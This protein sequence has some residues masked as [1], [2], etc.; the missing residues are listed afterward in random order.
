M[1][2]HTAAQFRLVVGF[3]GS[4]G[5][6]RA[7]SWAADEARQRSAKLEVVRAWTPG[8]FGTNEEMGTLT[9][10]RLEEDLA[11]VLGAPP[12]G[13]VAAVAIQGHAAKVLLEQAQDADMLVVGSRGHGG[14]TGLV[15]GSVGVHLATHDSAPVVVIVRH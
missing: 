5:S 9:Q 14:F 13:E 15:L 7:L 12:E 11:S 4:D 3:D 2:Q 1:A 8:E 10:K 6:R